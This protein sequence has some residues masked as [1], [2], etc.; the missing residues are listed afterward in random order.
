MSRNPLSKEELELDQIRETE[1]QL[2]KREKESAEYRKKI[3][4]ERSEMDST[5]PPLY[6]IQVRIAQKRHELVVSRGE[7]ENVLRTQNRSILLLLLLV[8]ATASLIWWG[9]KLMQAG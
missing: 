5:M 4:R 6:E 2:L 7:V 3:A 8:T 9:L 1:Q